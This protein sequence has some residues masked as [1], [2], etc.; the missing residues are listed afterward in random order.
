METSFLID[1]QITKLNDPNGQSNF[2]RKIN[3]LIESK[4]KI[5]IDDNP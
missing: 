5:R 2:Q 1:D 4:E 3:D